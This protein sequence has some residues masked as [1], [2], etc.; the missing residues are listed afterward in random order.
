[1][2]LDDIAER[3]KEQLARDMA[4]VPPNEVR[5]IAEQAAKTDTGRSFKKALI[6]FPSPAIIAEVK[7]ASPSKGVICE[8]FRPAEQAA[9]YE[10]AGA[11]A[12]SC[13][14]EE[15]YFKGS[16]EYFK[17]VRQTVDIPM[18]RKDF[19]IDPYQIYEAKAMGAD[20]VLLIA[21][22]LTTERLSEYR[23]LA[24]SL[25][26]DVLAESH[27]EE[28]LQSVIEAGCTIFGI[29]NRNLKDFS[30][31]LET[32]KRLSELVPKGGIIVAES[33][34]KTA[35]DMKF[36]ADCGANAVLI[37][38]TLMRSGSV[39]NSVKELRSLI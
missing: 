10:K 23:Q 26:M 15:Y 28:E 37:G 27:N 8:D 25:G 34:I 22:I 11:A 33:G 14:T 13:L 19:I 24:E 18:I 35:E 39:E 38:E 9:A 30:V 21:A 36:L 1:M 17:E 12:V 4:N 29:N 6:S 32:T 20:A 16:A 2:I 5:E 31:T 3:R 7:K